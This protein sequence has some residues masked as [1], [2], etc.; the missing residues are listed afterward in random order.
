MIKISKKKFAI[1]QISNSWNVLNW[2]FLDFP[3]LDISKIFKIL[4]FSKLQIFENANF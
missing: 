1:F 4:N 2:K 3:K